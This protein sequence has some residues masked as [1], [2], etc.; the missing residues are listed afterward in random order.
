M[1]SDDTTE[2][3]SDGVTVNGNICGHWDFDSAK[4]RSGRV[5]SIHNLRE[6]GGDNVLRHIAD[7]GSCNESLVT[8]DGERYKRTY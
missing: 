6:E 4:S 3:L 5:Q 7:D 2:N 1:Y 8:G